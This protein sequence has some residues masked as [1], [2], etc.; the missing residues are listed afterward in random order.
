MKY[1]I[2]ALLEKYRACAN[3]MTEEFRQFFRIF[4]YQN[5]DYKKIKITKIESLQS[6]DSVLSGAGFYLIASTMPTPNNGCRLQIGSSRVIYR[7]H[8]SNVRERLESHLFYGS[9]T[10]KNAGR[11]FTVCM[12]LNGKNVN[13]DECSK[14]DDDWYVVTHSM[15]KSM[16]LIREAAEAAFDAEFGKPVC[17]TK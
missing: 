3:D 1:D 4:D 13:L 7:G 10:T 2:N 8:S 15:P 14:I 17:S 11:K 12:K 9:Y 16:K 5:N 6:L